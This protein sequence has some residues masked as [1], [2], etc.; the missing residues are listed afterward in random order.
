MKK[1]IGWKELVGKRV[2]VKEPP[3]SALSEVIVREV[4]PS[5]EYVCLDF[6]S[7]GGASRVWVKAEKY[8]VVEILSDK[9]SIYDCWVQILSKL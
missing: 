8:V 6:S 4:S 7:Q 2:L 9:K 5:G 1:E 3:Y